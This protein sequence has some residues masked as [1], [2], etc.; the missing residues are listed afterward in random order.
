MK[1]LE[2]VLSKVNNEATM[3]SD[4]GCS[5]TVDLNMVLVCDRSKRGVIQRT[6]RPNRVQ[7]LPSPRKAGAE[8]GFLYCQSLLPSL[9]RHTCYH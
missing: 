9:Q 2:E 4:G 6:Y 1:H 7:D 3:E 5:F 8:N